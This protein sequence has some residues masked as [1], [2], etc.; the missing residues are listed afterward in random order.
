MVKL[1]GEK[2]MLR[3]FIPADKFDHEV[4]RTTETEWQN[5]DAPWCTDRD[6]SSVAEYAENRLRRLAI[7]ADDD[8]R[9]TFELCSY[10]EGKHIGWMNCYCIDRFCRYATHDTG[11]YALGIDIV[12]PSYRGRGIG[13]EAYKLFEDYLLDFGITQTYVQTWSGNLPMM[14]LAEKMGY[15]PY[16]YKKNHYVTTDGSFA[17][18]TF[19]KDLCW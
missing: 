10:P 5:W 13:A 7:I 4:W 12:P 19:K 18:V 15:T 1:I 6:L 14:R 11:R 9:W 16:K 2:A 8:I 17:L 3:D